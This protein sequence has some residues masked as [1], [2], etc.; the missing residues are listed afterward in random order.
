MDG[1]FKLAHMKKEEEEE[2]IRERKEN[3]SFDDFLD[4]FCTN[5][6]PFGH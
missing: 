4:V 6:S 3:W 2:L 1:H 5:M